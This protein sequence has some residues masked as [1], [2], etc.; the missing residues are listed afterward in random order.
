MKLHRPLVEAVAEALFQI[1]Q[2]GKYAD[3]VIERLLKSNPRWGSRD[4]AFIAENTYE[5][6]RWW[7]LYEEIWKFGNLEIGS[8]QMDVMT[9]IG[10]H[11][12]LK[13]PEAH[14]FLISNFREIEWPSQEVVLL[15]KQSLLADLRTAQSIPDWMDEVGTSELGEKWPAEITALNE[16]APVV[17]RANR[18]KT[19]KLE[20]KKRLAEEGW[21]TQETSLAPD[22]LVLLRRGNIFQSKTFLTGLFEVQDAG[23][24][25]I[26][27][28][29]QV[30]PGMRVV[31]ACAG[32]G[33]KSLHLAALMEN[34]GSIISLDTEAWKLEELRKRARRSGAHIIQARPIDSSKTI[35]RLHGTADRLLLDVPCSGLGTLRRNPD[36]KW[37]LSLEFLEKVRA[38]QTEILRSYAK[39][40]RPGGQLVYATCSVLPSENERQVERF[41][42]E[43][44]DFQLLEQRTISP[45]EHGFDG[46][47]MASLKMK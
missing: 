36:A 8:R 4:R 38:T 13:Y 6:V 30:E 9:L 25:C 33:G 19:N 39:I 29:L 31:D 45:A 27:P 43:N 41:L 46:F 5:M 24:Q 32:A 17:V 10:I 35:K 7:R 47:F 20:L 21:E 15:Q 12:M 18:L 22:A 3:K 16:P 14:H 42:S 2:E 44:T 1:F 26:A 40:L 23:S 37:K 28:Y 11:L 34:K